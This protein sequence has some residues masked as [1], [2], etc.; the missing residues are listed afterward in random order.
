MTKNAH[1]QVWKNVGSTSMAS[2]CVYS[3]HFP[4][5]LAAHFLHSHTRNSHWA[6]YFSF[7]TKTHSFGIQKG[8][9]MRKISKNYRPKYRTYHCVWKAVNIFLFF[10]IWKLQEKQ[11]SSESLTDHANWLNKN[12]A[13]RWVLNFDIVDSVAT[14]MCHAQNRKSR[15]HFLTYKFW[16]QPIW[17]NGLSHLYTLN[18]PTRYV[19]CAAK[20]KKN[21]LCCGNEFDVTEKKERQPIQTKR[22]LSFNVCFLSLLLDTMLRM[23]GQ[24]A[25]I[26]SQ[27][28]YL[29][30]VSYLQLHA[31]KYLNCRNISAH[32]RHI[33]CLVCE[34]VYAVWMRARESEWVTLNR[35]D[36]SNFVLNLLVFVGR[37]VYVR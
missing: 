6:F 36:V 25:R 9:A 2:L 4:L 22:L 37:T 8:L 15:K 21:T 33:V 14:V 27:H 17:I 13:N 29:T 23:H 10:H 30:H 34:L 1:I 32:D 24:Y 31:N 35:I 20:K 11:H 3:S 5:T 26:Q 12:A 19:L 28:F 18:E 7:E 16:I